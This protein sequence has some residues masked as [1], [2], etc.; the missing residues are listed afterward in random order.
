MEMLF[1]SITSFENLYLAFR[2]V[3][4]G[5]RHQETV[6][7]FERN[8]EEEFIIICHLLTAV[9]SACLAMITLPQ[10]SISSLS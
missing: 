2:K 9:R 7:A 8:Q 10:A 3:R 4:L 5:K 6:A 1:D